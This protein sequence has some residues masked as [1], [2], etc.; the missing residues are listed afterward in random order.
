M[1]CLVPQDQA[2][3]AGRFRRDHDLT[4]LEVKESTTCGSLTYTR[5]NRLTVLM[6]IDCPTKTCSGW[7]ADA[8]EL[9]SAVVESGN[10]ARCKA[11]PTKRSEPALPA[12][13]GSR[14]LRLH[15]SHTAQRGASA[16]SLSVFVLVAIAIRA[17]VESSSQLA[18]R[19]EWSPLDRAYAAA[20]GRGRCGAGGSGARVPVSSSSPTEELDD[21][22][23]CRR[24]FSTQSESPPGSS[25]A[26][27]FPSPPAS[28][29]ASPRC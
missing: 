4:G 14:C 13:G 10:F 8:V 3:H 25:P 26:P 23:H 18:Y 15:H 29:A 11:R 7:L 19:P 28:A 6:K 27:A 22:V 24:R 12:G 9:V 16:Q 5:F 20:V 21:C 1:A 2:A 17:S